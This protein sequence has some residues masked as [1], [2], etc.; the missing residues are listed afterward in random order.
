MTEPEPTPFHGNPYRMDLRYLDGEPLDLEHPRPCPHCG[1][2]AFECEQC[3]EWHDACI[4]HIDGASVACCGHGDL[5]AAHVSWPERTVT[6]L[7]PEHWDGAREATIEEL[8]RRGAEVD[9]HYRQSDA[10]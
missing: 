8:L 10:Q 2:A 6:G 9:V 5:E 3:D 1:C 4:G 7:G